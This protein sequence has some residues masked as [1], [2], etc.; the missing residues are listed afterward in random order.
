MNNHSDNECQNCK[1][2]NK[3]YKKIKLDN[4][5][6]TKKLLKLES[7]IH[8]LNAENKKLKK[9]IEVIKQLNYDSIDEYFQ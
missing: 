5:Q 1:E 8:S 3:E 2:Y 7:Q 6:L 9:E 4:S